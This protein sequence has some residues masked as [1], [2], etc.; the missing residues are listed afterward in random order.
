VH[1]AAVGALQVLLSLGAL[2]LFAGDSLSRPAPRQG[3]V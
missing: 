3:S 1:P 2:V